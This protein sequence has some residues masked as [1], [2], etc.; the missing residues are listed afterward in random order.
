MRTIQLTAL[1]GLILLVFLTGCS[2]Q[3]RTLR[4]GFHVERIGALNKKPSL[5][6]QA[7]ETANLPVLPNESVGLS[8]TPPAT[9]TFA[10]DAESLGKLE[11]LAGL[12]VVTPPQTIELGSVQRELSRAQSDSTGTNPVEGQVNPSDE[13]KSSYKLAW[14]STDWFWISLILYPIFPFALA[15][16]QID[17]RRVENGE[18][19]LSRKSKTIFFTLLFLVSLLLLGGGSS[20]GFS[21][22]SFRF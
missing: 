17:F 10:E 22:F 9:E 2:I 21:S 4:P 11:D 14:Y 19:P 1:S 18:E 12:A 8:F 15:C 16:R 5:Q 13:A 3:K 7:Q 6:V 20:F